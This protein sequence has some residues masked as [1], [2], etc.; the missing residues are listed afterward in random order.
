[1]KHKSI[2]IWSFR[3]APEEYRK[4]STNGGDEDWLVLIPASECNDYMWQ[5]RWLTS[6]DSCNEPQEIVMPN[7]DRVYIGSHA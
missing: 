7:G 1:M 5:P 2:K 6:I 3:H 4:L